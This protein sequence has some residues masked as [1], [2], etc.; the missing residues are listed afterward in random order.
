MTSPPKKDR[1]F[2][3]PRI[4]PHPPRPQNSSITSPPPHSAAS[5]M[6]FSYATMPSSVWLPSPIDSRS[7]TF[8]SSTTLST[9]QRQNS[10]PRPPVLFPGIESVRQQSIPLLPSQPEPTTHFKVAV[11]GPAVW[12]FPS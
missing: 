6:L 4:H 12:R 5:H 7:E 3:H 11:F 9:F 2:R 10:V 8:S 1:L